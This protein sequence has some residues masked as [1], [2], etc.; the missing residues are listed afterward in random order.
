LPGALGKESFFKKI[1]TSLPTLSRP[2]LSAKVFFFKYGNYLCRQPDTGPRHVFSKKI[3]NPLFADGPAM[4]PSAKRISKTV[5]FTAL[6]AI[7]LVDGRQ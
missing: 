1:K 3:K 2:L 4:R 5:N 6:T 7:F